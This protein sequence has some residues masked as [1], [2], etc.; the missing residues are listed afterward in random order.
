MGHKKTVEFS[1]EWSDDGEIYGNCEEFGAVSWGGGSGAA[2]EMSFWQQG[3]IYPGG[4]YVLR[5]GDE[6]RRF[7]L[8]L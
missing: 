2:A 1:T 4:E 7:G 6:L 8:L 5:P 3:P